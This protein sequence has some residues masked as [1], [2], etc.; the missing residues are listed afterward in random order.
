[1]G[2]ASRDS[3]GFGALDSASLK[4][5]VSRRVTGKQSRG[6]LRLRQL[7][8]ERLLCGVLIPCKEVNLLAF[9]FLEFNKNI[10]AP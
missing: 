1:M 3:T 2:G 4:L 7:I 6:G 8:E 10:Y 5:E 9:F